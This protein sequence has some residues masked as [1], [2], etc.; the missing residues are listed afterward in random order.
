MRPLLENVLTELRQLER[1]IQ[2]PDQDLSRDQIERLLQLADGL[3]T[4]EC[5]PLAKAASALSRLPARPTLR[6]LLIFM[7]P[8]E[9]AAGR[10]LKDSDFIVRTKDRSKPLTENPPLAFVL[11]NLRSA[12][13]VGSVIRLADAVG[14]KVVG[15]GY[16]PTPDSDGIARTS[17]GSVA[18]WESYTSLMEGMRAL[19]DDGFSLVALE[20]ADRAQS[21]YTGQLPPR[22][23]LIVGNE[24]FGLESSILTGCDEVRLVPQLG[25]KNSLNVAVALGVAAYE[26]HRQWKL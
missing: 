9:R 12:F 23:A 6:Q 7:V 21:I 8:F 15:C 16:T 22:T 2:H 19:R 11:E 18:P 10:S 14:A 13:N 4:S 20:T 25:Q 5:E 17:L 26:W 3:R 24:R 1:S